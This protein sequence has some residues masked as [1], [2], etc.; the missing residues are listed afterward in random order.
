[1]LAAG[2]V[3]LTRRMG[4]SSAH[5]TFLPDEDAALLAELGFLHRT[6][7]QF[8]FTEEMCQI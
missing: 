3:E 1:M 2:L 4:V 8:H 7:Q 6:D 5:I